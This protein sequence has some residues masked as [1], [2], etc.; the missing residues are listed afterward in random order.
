[1]TARTSMAAIVLACAA[2]AAPRLVDAQPQGRPASPSTRASAAPLTV[3]SPN[4]ALVVTVGVDEHLTWSVALRG[5]AILLPSRIGMTLANAPA[6][7]AKPAVASTSTRTVDQVLRP[8]VRIKRAEV[9]D[10]YNERR[11][12][13]A[14]GYALIVR[15]YDDGVAYRF[16]TSLPGEITV[17]AED[18]SLAWD[19]DHLVYFPEE[20]SFQSHQERPYKQVKISEIG[21]RFSGLPAM[22]VLP[23]GVKAVITEADLFDYPGMDLTGDGAALTLRG[24][25]PA[26]PKKV[27]LRRDRDEV[28]L[29]RENY[30]AKTR[31]TREF[32]WRAVVVAERDE[33]LLDTDIVYRLA[34]ETTMQDT[35][36][37]WPGLVAW[38]WWNANNVFGVPF[39]AG[40]NTETYKHYIDFA[41]EQGI[42]YIILDEGWY[43]LGNL[44]ATVPAID[45]NA[46]AAHAQ[47][48]HVGLIM[49]VVWKTLDLQMQPALDQFA[50][51]GVKGIKVDFMQREDQWMVNFYERVAHEAAKRRLLVDFHGAYKPTGLYRTYPHVVT[52]EGVLGL[53]QSKWSDL[54]SPENA[55]TFPFM[56][57][58]AGPVDYT[59]GAMMNATKADFKPV[60]NRPGSQ[61]TRC[62][63]LAM[64][65]VYES[66]L[67]MLADA[68][69]NYRK[70]P[71]SLAFL[72]RVPTVWDETRVL[73]AKVGEYI[74]T[75]RRSG[76]DWY[77][78]AL[79]NW[80]ARDI[81]VEL[82][83]LGAGAFTADVFR[84]GPN[85][86]R[87]G[88]DYERAELA[89]TAGDKLT[90]RLAPGGGFAARITPR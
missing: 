48:K 80:T 15:A 36:W 44:L 88:V 69:S 35:G 62:Q 66:P 46:I 90:L 75:A 33:T 5:R 56:R 22:V 83:W 87:A 59:P 18:A 42:P 19:G 76:R 28:V 77:L 74:V 23:D 31:G 72:S 55:V 8:V 24:L 58:L 61:G 20:T 71:E 13:F 60:F 70:E 29:E 52:S 6:L 16:A 38:D 84:D 79:T 30:L 34:S 27:E 12:N 63:Q 9:R 65:V 1:M 78:G 21:Q 7:G 50:R 51:W 57:M 40:V 49:W 11:V 10:H 32:P 67:Q 26:Y 53:E 45:M 3:A 25:F 89:L 85:A 81:E 2:L 54:A 43:P 37:I 86:H 14:G 64:Y 82:S 39:R 17:T 47:A 4:G 68:P 41:A 73:T